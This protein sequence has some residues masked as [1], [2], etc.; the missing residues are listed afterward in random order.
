MRF[1]DTKRFSPVIYGGDLPHKY[2]LYHYNELEVPT[3]EPKYI[4]FLND[5]NIITDRAWW[6]KQY[7]RCIEGYT[8]QNAIEKGGDSFRDGIDAIWLGDKVYLPQLD[9]IING[10]D[11][12]ITGRMYFYLNFWKIRRKD[13]KT[14]R[15]IIGP[16][17]FTS[18]SW[19]NWI[20]RHIS[21]EKEKDL[22]WAK[23]RQCLHGD[24]FIYT[25]EGPIKIKDLIGKDNINL[26]S[27]NENKQIVIDKCL[28][29]W[30][31]ES[32]E[33]IEIKAYNGEKLICSTDHL[34]NT[35][36]GWKEAGKLK[37][38]DIVYTFEGIKNKY[39]SRISKI[40][41]VGVHELYD[42]ITEETE[43]FFANGLHVHNCGLSEETAA[44]LAYDYLFIKDS[45]TAIVAGQESYATNTFKMVKRG[46]SKL[47]NTQFY[48]WWSVSNS[49]LLKAKYYGSEIHCKTAKNNEQALSGLSP[50]KVLYEEG[51]IWARGLLKETAEF[52]NQSLEAEGTKTGQNVFISTAGDMED[53]VADVEE[54]CYN[55]EKFNLLSFKNIYEKEVSSRDANVAC[56]IPGWEFEVIDEEGNSL[57]KESEEKLNKDRQSKATKERMRAITMKPFYLSELFSNVSGGYFGEMIVHMLNERKAYLYTHRNENVGAYYRLEWKNPRNWDEGVYAVEDENGYV[58]ITE[59]PESDKDGNIYSNVYK[60]GTDSYDKD[61]ANESNSKGSIHIFKGFLNAS[62]TYKKWVARIIQRPSIEEGGAYI[63]YENTIKLGIYY[64]VINLIEWSNI[65]IFDYY[66]R[67]GME[68]LLKERPEMTISKYIGNSKTNNVF[69]IDPSTK[70][71]WLSGL[72]DYLSFKENIDKMDDIEQIQAFAK[73]KYDPSGKKYNCDITISSALSLV[74]YEDETEL[75]AVSTDQYGSALGVTAYIEENGRIK[76]IAI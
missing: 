4:K 71:H 58:F 21:V 65:R 55:P 1:I 34:I 52:V 35:D 26:Y 32:K 29:V 50:H 74:C 10:T 20:I 64:S 54:M 70:P 18:L 19:K 14:N 62:T 63:F 46:I 6:K 75:E 42:L 43:S 22:L 45:Q 12:W 38:G 37:V 57:R 73:F 9:Y 67:N 5:N 44:D 76:E 40:K 25:T 8:V 66:K 47:I 33:C 7:K 59:H 69:G 30:K 24:T 13:D 49:E 3:T 2:D 68:H 17:R 16:P 23:K 11:V 56:F 48:K 72:R 39:E 15:K 53:G 51:G 36:K 27:L 60:A 31:T 28:D 41:E 61:E